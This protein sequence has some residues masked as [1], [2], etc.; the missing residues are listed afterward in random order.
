MSQALLEKLRNYLNERFR[1]E[2]NT[3]Q[4][5]IETRD[6]MCYDEN[7]KNGTRKVGNRDWSIH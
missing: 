1:N 2:L 3:E 5:K 6:V 7:K 4:F